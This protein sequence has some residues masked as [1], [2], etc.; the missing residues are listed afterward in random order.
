MET[1]L[2]TYY[3]LGGYSSRRGGRNIDGPIKRWKPDTSV[4]RATIQFAKETER[5]HL[6]V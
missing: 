6:T 2:G 5:L 1:D 3:V 4:V